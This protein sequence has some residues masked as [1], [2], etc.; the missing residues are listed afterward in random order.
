MEIIL[1]KE[2]RRW[3]EADKRRIVLE[4]FEPGV[5]CLSVARRHQISNG[6]LFTW[7]KRLREELGFPDP[8]SS[9]RF[10]PLAVIG[11]PERPAPTNHPTSAPTIEV[12]VGGRRV[13]VSGAASVELVGVVV[14]A[15]ARK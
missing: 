14:N 13:W 9:V 5:T 15:L 12:D 2:R 11:E 8:T 4:T 1:G 6:M 3:S 10:A 7:R